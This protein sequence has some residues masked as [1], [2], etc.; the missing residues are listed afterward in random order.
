MKT[1]QHACQLYKRISALYFVLPKGSIIQPFIGKKSQICPQWPPTGLKKWNMAVISGSRHLE[2]DLCLKRSDKAWNFVVVDSSGCYSVMN[3]CDISNI[4]DFFSFHLASS[5]C[6]VIIRSKGT[7]KHD[8]S[9]PFLS[10]CHITECPSDSNP[11]SLSGHWYRLTTLQNW[12]MGKMNLFLIDVELKQVCACER[13][14]N[15]S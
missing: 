6:N 8:L 4:F 15:I 1:K 10:N 9:K 11:K 3:K 2:T 7:T 14:R 13:W 5:L 12:R